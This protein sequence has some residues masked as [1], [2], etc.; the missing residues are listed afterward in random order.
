MQVGRG[1][2]Y[3]P[4]PLSLFKNKSHYDETLH[5]HTMV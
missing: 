5:S 1:L 2:N 4:P 3:K